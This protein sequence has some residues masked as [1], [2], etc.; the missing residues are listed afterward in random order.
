[1]LLCPIFLHFFSFFLVEC[2]F[3]VFL[4]FFGLEFDPRKSTKGENTR[5]TLHTCSIYIL[6]SG[7]GRKSMRDSDLVRSIAILI[8]L[9]MAA[10]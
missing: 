3:N 2:I 1:M 9:F 10:R 6:G 7:I 5:C 8:L 4:E